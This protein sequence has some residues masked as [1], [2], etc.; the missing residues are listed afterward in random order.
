[1]QLFK[2]TFFSIPILSFTLLHI[3]SLPLSRASSSCT[4]DLGNKITDCD[5]CMRHLGCVWCNDREPNGMAR[6]CITESQAMSDCDKSINLK[7]SIEYI[8]DSPLDTDSSDKIR[9]FPQEVQLTLRPNHPYELDFEVALSDNPV[10]IYFLMDLSSS[11][12]KSKSNLVDASESIARRI[13]EL[14]SSFKIGFGSFSDKLVPPFG[15]TKRYSDSRNYLRSYSYRH[16]MSLGTDVEEFRRRVQFSDLAG[17][18]DSPESGLEALS[19]AI[20]CEEEIGWTPG[21]VRRV[22]I[23][24]SDKEQHFA[25]DG[26]MGGLY[27]MS[28]G[29]CELSSVRGETYLTYSKSREY[30]YPSFGQIRHELRKKNV[31]VIFAIESF[32]VSLYRD[33]SLFLQGTDNVGALTEDPSSIEEIVVEQYQSIKNRISMTVNSSHHGLLKCTLHGD[34]IS[35]KTLKRQ[36]SDLVCNDVETQKPYKFKVKVTASSDLCLETDTDGQHKS[37]S[38]QLQGYEKDQLSV[39]AKCAYCSCPDVEPGSR[40]CSGNGNFICGGCQCYDGFSGRNCE[41]NDNDVL[42]AQNREDS[43]KFES[44]DEVCNGRGECV[45]AKCLCSGSEYLGKACQCRSKDCPGF[46]SS[47]GICNGKG[48]CECRESNSTT[49]T[50]KCDEGFSGDNCDCPTS[51]ERCRAALTGDD[52]CSGK[53]E[54]ICGK[55]QNCKDGYRGDFCQID[56][57]ISVCNKLSPCIKHFLLRKNS[58]ENE[59]RLEKKLCSSTFIGNTFR[60]YLNMGCKIQDDLSLEDS[61]FLLIGDYNDCDQMEQRYNQSLAQKE[62]EEGNDE[63][64]TRGD[65]GRIE[66]IR[67]IDTADFKFCTFRYG[68]CNIEYFH[69][70]LDSNDIYEERK[71]GVVYVVYSKNKDGVW[72]PHTNCREGLSLPLIL[73]SSVG[74]LLLFGLITLIAFCAIVTT[75]D[76]RAYGQYEAWKAENIRNLQGN[77]NPTYI[78]PRSIVDN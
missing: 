74:S 40:K 25:L 77:S 42:N 30:D 76:K 27:T 23:F 37:F 11:M 36:Q 68:D 41:C 64:P 58:T 16:Q 45:C 18:V 50:C 22:I 57:V 39:K 52:V 56:P 7:N 19:Q 26:K 71:S 6:G 78:Q 20:L 51:D 32:M 70:R 49:P 47:S 62:D 17:N 65:L 10:D 24:I 13:S 8:R 35:E 31:V 73:G 55:C 2:T 15:M 53:G 21:D 59:L 28:Q 34:C 60:P 43:C 14:S 4:D 72:S 33:L 66:Q 1:M 44:E 29:K 9:V 54:C 61:F 46:S 67:K 48:I 5:A 3:F 75:R 69:N 12:N 63:L 38:I